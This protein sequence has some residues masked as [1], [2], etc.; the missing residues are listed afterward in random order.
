[1]N[2][3]KTKEQYP[4][5]SFCMVAYNEEKFIAEAVKAAFAQDYP[6][7]EIILSDDCSSDRTYE[8]MKE[9]AAAY[10]GPHKVIL[11]RNNPNLGPR[12]N[13]NKVLY[14]LAHGEYLFIAAGDDISRKDRVSIC[15]DL[16]EKHQEV[17]S[18]SVASK[19]IDEEGNEIP[20]GD[21]NRISTGQYSIY[22]LADYISYDF[23]LFSGDSRV[24]RRKVIEAFP[25]LQFSYA[26][27]T[28]LFV[29]SFM[30]GNV[31]YLRE[32]LVCYRQRQNSIMWKSRKKKKTK[33]DI[34][35]FK[36]TSYKQ[37]KADFDLAVKNDYLTSAEAP[38]VEW[39]I[40]QLASWLR[41]KR[42]TIW[43]RCAHR[44]SKYSSALFNK[45]L[46]YLE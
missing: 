29:R 39:K 11:N 12:E 21:W 19:H 26:E 42:K 2:T 23:Y 45:I 9:M 14:E 31:A 22:T 6:N 32:P 1:M 24:L 28:M 27:D 40:E 7:M 10:K 46:N 17:M 38:F 33:D 3:N 36:E 41:P 35:R 25:P 30:L 37:L 8:I 16:M 20:L 4:L 15:V 44:L 5:A 43:W 18:M 34:R 13:F